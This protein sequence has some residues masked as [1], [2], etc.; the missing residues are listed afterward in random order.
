LG[1]PRWGKL[2]QKYTNLIVYSAL[3]NFF[4]KKQP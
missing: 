3:L 2:I 4:S 1:S